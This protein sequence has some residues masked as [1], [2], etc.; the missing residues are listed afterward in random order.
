MKTAVVTGATGFIGT[1]LVRKLSAA[2]V[3]VWAICRTGS[4][5]INRIR[6]CHNATIVECEFTD[7]VSVSEKAMPEKIDVIYHLAW[8]NASGPSRSDLQ[9]Q[10][11][12]IIIVDQ[13]VRLAQKKKVDKI[14][15]SGTVSENLCDRIQQTDKFVPAAYYLFSKRYVKNILEQLSYQKSFKLVWITFCHP[16]GEYNKPDQLITKTI[17]DLSNGFSPQFGI[18]TNMFDVIAVEDLAAALY[19][20]GEKGLHKTCY[21]VGS[22]EPKQLRQYLEKVR[23][24]ISP[25]ANLSFGSLPDDGL[26][27]DVK[28]FDDSD[29]R[30]E[31]GFATQISIEEA[32]MR[33]SEWSAK[34]ARLS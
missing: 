24:I 29:F 5:N 28:W 21:Y 12:N 2:G 8:E 34:I 32:I 31:T 27:L 20:A 17:I 15:V 23:D 11:K 25:N 6:D 13:V 14:I 4:E 18:A 22:G 16:I 19:L 3:K 26:A 33:T 1:H 9:S 7:L 10:I 30:K